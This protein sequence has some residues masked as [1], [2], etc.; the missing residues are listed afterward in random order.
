LFKSTTANY[1]LSYYSW[2]PYTLY[3]VAD[4]LITVDDSGTFYITYAPV[5]AAIPYQT[6]VI[7]LFAILGMWLIYTLFAEKR[8]PRMPKY[9]GVGA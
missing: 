8:R 9:H 2:T 3:T 4:G 5:Q 7:T 1:T 6:L